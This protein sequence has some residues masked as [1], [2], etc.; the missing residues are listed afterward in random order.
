LDLLSIPIRKPR[1]RIR[2][3]EKNGQA[4]SIFSLIISLESRLSNKEEERNN[5]K[6]IITKD[7]EKP[8]LVFVIFVAWES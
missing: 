2:N 8:E 7:Q 5:N 6:K 4:V 3:R 1:Q